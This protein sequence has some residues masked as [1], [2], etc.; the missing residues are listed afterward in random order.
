MTEPA[1]LSVVTAKTDLLCF[2]ICSG[3]ATATPAGGTSPY[4]YS[5]DDPGTQTGTG[6]THTATGLCSGLVNVTVT[7][8]N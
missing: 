3:D 4:S 5:W 2:E 8:D 6:V 1:V 7:D